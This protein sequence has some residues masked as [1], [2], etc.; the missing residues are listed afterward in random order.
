LLCSIGNINI[1]TLRKET[2]FSRTRHPISPLWSIP[3]ITSPQTEPLLCPA[4]SSV[5]LGPRVTLR[6]NPVGCSFRGIRAECTSYKI[7]L[8]NLVSSRKGRKIFHSRGARIWPVYSRPPHT[9]FS[10]LSLLK[11]FRRW[12]DGDACLP[13]AP[14]PSPASSSTV[15]HGSPAV[16]GGARP[17]IYPYA[18]EL[19]NVYGGTLSSTIGPVHSPDR[20]CPR[21]AFEL[22]NVY[23]GSLCSTTGSVHSPGW[24]YPRSAFELANVYGGTLS[25]TIGSVH[26][27][28]WPYPRSSLPPTTPAANY[29]A[30]TAATFAV[31]PPTPPGLMLRMAFGG[32]SGDG[33][34]GGAGGWVPEPNFAFGSGRSGAAEKATDEAGGG[35]AA[36]ASKRREWIKHFRRELDPKVRIGSNSGSL[37]S[38]DACRDMT[39]LHCRTVKDGCPSIPDDVHRGISCKS[40][41]PTKLWIVSLALYAMECSP[42]RPGKVW[43]WMGKG[44][45]N[46]WGHRR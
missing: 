31:T 9:P 29:R 25:S 8:V 2:Y 13:G 46:G 15:N 33:G 39:G 37:C 22:A 32:G 14:G 42:S 41:P 4:D 34:G 12:V 20:P 6:V 26:S 36:G 17:S 23:G 24:P 11:L 40:S 18:F 7:V 35:W 43:A 1:P 5:V 30:T 28:G 27:P 16:G 21:S 19:A 10:V 38:C 44:I 3:S 45:P